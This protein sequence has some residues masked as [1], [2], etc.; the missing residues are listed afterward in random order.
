VRRAPA[1][2]AALVAVLGMASA[3]TPQLVADLSEHLIA[4]NTGFTGTD[5][6]LF[7]A[8]EGEGD[9][10]VIVR[11]PAKTVT[12]REKQ[13]SFGIWL[14]GDSLTFGGVPSF[15]SVAANRPIDQLAGPVTLDR[16]GIGL[17][18]LRLVPESGQDVG[19]DKEAVFRAALLRSMQDR[20]LYVA[21]T[22]P[23]TFLSGRLFRT[24][25]QIPANVPTGRYLVE[26]FLFKDGKAVSAQTTPL[27]V[28]KVGIGAALF[29]LAEEKPALYGLATVLA[30]VAAGWLASVVFRRG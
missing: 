1:P 5:V 11:G 13:R 23:V 16:E 6:V 3:A 28:G 25:L 17:N 2:I 20:Q 15:Y 14:N 10:A 18:H 24:T 9:V 30:A 8:T 26:V 4:I 27:V 29:D 7:G 22:A 19:S 12:I 21:E